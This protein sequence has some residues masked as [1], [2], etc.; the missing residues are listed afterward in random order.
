[1]DLNTDDLQ[2][3]TVPSNRPSCGVLTCAETLT[4]SASGNSTTNQALHLTS[5][6]IFKN[7]PRAGAGYQGSWQKLA[8]VTLQQPTFTRVSD[9]IRASGKLS[10]QR[11]EMSL[12]LFKTHDCQEGRFSCVAVYVDGRG[13]TSVTKSIVGKGVDSRQE[14]PSPKLSTPKSWTLMGGHRS[15]K[16][17]DSVVGLAHILDSF[18]T[19][20]D[21]AMTRLD[22]SLKH[23]ENRMEDKVGA[24]QVALDN[25]INYLENR[26]EDKVGAMQVALDNRI[27]YL[28]N[29][30]EDKLVN[31]T[32]RIAEVF[33]G[34][35]NSSPSPGDCN[36][37]NQ[38]S[39]K[40]N[41]LEN[42]IEDEIG[43][44]VN[45]VMRHSFGERENISAQLT[46]IEDSVKSLESNF[47]LNHENVNRLE[48]ASD[49]LALAVAETDNKVS[50]LSS[51]V[52]T[53]SG[54]TH[55]L[56]SRFNTF[57]NSYAGGALVPVEEFSDAFQI[58]KREW[59]L[60]FRGTAYN[61][62]QL[63]P[64]YM[65]G[66]GIPLEVEEGCKQFNR[67]LPCV[68]H[69][70]NRQAFDNWV[71]I[72][73]VLFAI[74]KDDQ[75]VQNVVFNGK[76]S[77]YI[78]WF[79]AG[80]VIQSSWADLTSETHNYF[81]VKG[82][83]STDPAHTR[84]FHINRSYVR[85]CDQFEGWFS[86]KDSVENGCA[87]ENTIAMPMFHYATGK[88]FADWTGSNVARADAIGIFL[89]YD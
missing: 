30:M 74:Y 32:I 5:M 15:H 12:D 7:R 77:T 23:L 24:M 8:E 82:Y 18:R 14:D 79:T 55:N 10:D 52:S 48:K 25:K 88:T 75:M 1:M 58:G 2:A 29:R 34:N 13:W 17:A 16:Q 66:T 38:L 73:E 46:S 51:G 89:K 43:T 44:C 40:L 4:P 26:M 19:M 11:A 64:A 68:N 78:N 20:F 33:G 28:E 41:E 61:N 83:E 3:K 71:G 81:S 22:G 65:H 36:V 6:A 80:R 50:A 21:A 86:V 72:D 42:K 85:G 87:A 63:Y 9:G 27:N 69:Y 60:V 57:S 45:K 39:S 53:L 62:V 47:S 70:R 31:L 35:S 84:R 49:R 67:S 56:V 54:L 37:C 59:K 76:G